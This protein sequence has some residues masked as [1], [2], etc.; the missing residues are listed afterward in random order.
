MHMK[1]KCYF[2][3]YFFQINDTKSNEKMRMADCVF[4]RKLFNITF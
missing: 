2:K 1:F 3:Y 4:I